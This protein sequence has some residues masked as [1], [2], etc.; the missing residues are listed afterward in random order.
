MVAPGD[1]IAPWA[2]GGYGRMRAS[3]AD[4]EQVIGS[5]KAAFVQGRLDKDEFDLRVSRTLTSRTYADLSA[6]TADLPAGLADIRPPR[7]VPAEGGRPGQIAAAATMLYGGGWVYALLS[8][9]QGG[10]NPAA[11]VM[12]YVATLI[13]LCVLIVV[14][15][16]AFEARHD[17]R[18]VR[19]LRRGQGPGSG[20]PAGRRLQPGKQG[21]QYP[22][23]APGH[24]HAAEAA[25][26]RRPPR[27]V[28]GDRWVRPFW[29]G[30]SP[31]GG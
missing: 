6:V 4:R 22:P 17:K 12:V 28:R 10:E 18:S 7:R 30:T 3:H 13:Y 1:G 2:A 26:S 27:P 5:L 9:S 14:A 29:L 15:G 11:I 19:Q 8:P 21:R 20:G 31:A 24:W 25:R 16:A 23:G